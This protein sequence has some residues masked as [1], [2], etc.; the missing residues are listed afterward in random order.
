[1][2]PLLLKFHQNW[3]PWAKTFMV[4]FGSCYFI[5]ENLAFSLGLQSI[6]K[7][8]KNLRS[9]TP[10]KDLF[11]ALLYAKPNNLQRHM[12]IK[13]IPQIFKSG[14][15][16]HKIQYGI[17]QLLKSGQRAKKKNALIQRMQASLE[18]CTRCVLIISFF[19]NPMNLIFFSDCEKASLFL[20]LGFCS[21]DAHEW[22]E[23]LWSYSSLLSSQRRTPGPCV[24]IA[25]YFYDDYERCARPEKII[26]PPTQP[27]PPFDRRLEKW[28][29]SSRRNISP[30]R[31]TWNWKNN[32]ALEA[33]IKFSRAACFP[34]FP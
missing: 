17:F 22:M 34:F 19:F 1:M 15:V 23:E 24:V 28:A 29:L 32:D 18:T 26:N 13:C 27:P 4:L 33:G 16:K 21:L 9:H 14:S 11:W 10:S 5:F 12:Q 30:A 3:W 2:I 31:S 8:R 25:C 20:Q 7:S 6:I